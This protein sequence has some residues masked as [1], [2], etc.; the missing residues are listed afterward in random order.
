MMY[1]ENSTCLRLQ[2]NSSTGRSSIQLTLLILVIGLLATGCRVEE[3]KDDTGRT[4]PLNI[5]AT[6]GMLAD[7]ARNIVRD[8]ADVLALM[9]PG[10]DPHLYKATQSDLGRLQGAD[11]VFYNGFNLEGKMGEILAKF[12]KQKPVMAVAETI[13]RTQLRIVDSDNRTVDPHIW[14]DVQLWAEAVQNI[15]Y[16]LQDLDPKRADY[17]QENTLAYLEELDSL[18]AWVY[19]EIQSIP[20]SQRVLITA[21]DAFGYFG[22][23]YD[24]EVRG[25]QGI[26]TQSELGV[27][28][29]SRLVNYITRH[30][31]KSVFLESSVSSQSLEAVVAGCKQRG[32]AIRIGG[33]L[34]SDAMDA[35]AKP[36]G[37]YIGM[38]RSNVQHI[39]AALR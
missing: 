29:V 22:E 32:H 10:V 21:H 1:T 6:T 8:S 25:L 12:S 28:D 5:V 3:S 39:T 15:S 16:K 37:N 30:R 35:P 17:Y 14:F 13:D 23:A 7:A 9:G 27:Q 33:M 36:E 11:V 2:L 31:I 34:Y 20:E 4:G 26:S 18:H 38:V 19:R 24:I